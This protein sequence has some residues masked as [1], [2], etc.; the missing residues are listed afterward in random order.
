[1]T[2]A[3]ASAQHRAL[4]FSEICERVV[5]ENVLNQY[6]YKTLPSPN[7]LW[8]FKKTMC[9]HMAMAG[10]R[11]EGGEGREGRE[12]GGGGRLGHYVRVLWSC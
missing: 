7:H 1:M 3:E 8:V 4:A 2:P 10:A 5:T 11:L 6:V 9:L 12:G